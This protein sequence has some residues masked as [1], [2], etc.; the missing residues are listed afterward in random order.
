MG[1]SMM[2]ALSHAGLYR[3][4][5]AAAHGARVFVASVLLALTLVH[6][7]DAAYSMTLLPLSLGVLLAPAI[8]GSSNEE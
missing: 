4:A 7:N 6:V 8:V 2:R 3:C 5:S 1:E